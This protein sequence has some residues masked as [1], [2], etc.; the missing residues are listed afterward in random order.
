MPK[1]TL[2]AVQPTATSSRSTRDRQRPR[3]F[4]VAPLVTASE[5][6]TSAPQPNPTTHKQTGIPSTGDKA[7]KG[8]VGRPPKRA[9]DT[10]P[11]VHPPMKKR[12]NKPLAK[13][14]SK[15]PKTVKNPV[16]SHG[17]SGGDEEEAKRAGEPSAAAVQ[18]VENDGKSSMHHDEMDCDNSMTDIEDEAQNDEDTLKTL[19]YAQSRQRAIRQR[20]P[21]LLALLTIPLMM[22]PLTPRRFLKLRIGWRSNLNLA[23]VAAHNPAHHF[24]HQASPNS[25]VQVPSQPMYRPTTN[26][27]PTANLSAILATLPAALNPSSH[28]FNMKMSAG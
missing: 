3:H 13:R 6:S 16:V 10:S 21:S 22:H 1:R 27:R 4:W 11:A 5:D 19:V 24:L 18:K 15:P 14:F 28:F 9:A 25:D 8:K 12:K 17:Y 20:R 7:T 26:L 2:P 23:Q